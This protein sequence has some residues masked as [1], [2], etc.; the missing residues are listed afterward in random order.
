MSN[1]LKGIPSIYYLNL[2]SEL[3]RRKYMARLQR[4]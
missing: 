3:D 4:I 2:D 1:K